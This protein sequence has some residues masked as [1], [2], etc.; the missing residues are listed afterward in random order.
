MRARDWPTH[1]G[2]HPQRPSPCPVQLGI[3]HGSG[4]S[5]CSVKEEEEL[6]PATMS[7]S[8]ATTE[9][10]VCYGDRPCVRSRGGSIRQRRR[11]RRGKKKLGDFLHSGSGAGAQRPGSPGGWAGCLQARSSTSANQALSGRLIHF[12]SCCQPEMCVMIPDPAAEDP[13]RPVKASHTHPHTRCCVYENPCSLI[14]GVN[15][16]LKFRLIQIF[17]QTNQIRAWN[18][19][20]SSRK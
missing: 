3:N 11:S 12:S 9:S 16:I 5:G 19:S 6:P 17:M 1:T 2:A 10:T 4:T 13:L 20:S 8:I 14:C 7:R 15:V 18:C